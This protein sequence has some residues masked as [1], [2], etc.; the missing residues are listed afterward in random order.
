MDTKL[1]V[2]SVGY[3]FLSMA[4]VVAIAALAAMG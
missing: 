1:I 2:S 4:I 3:A